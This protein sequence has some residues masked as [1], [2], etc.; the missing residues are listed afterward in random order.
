MT[1]PHAGVTKLLLTDADSW[2]QGVRV[3]CVGIEI[4]V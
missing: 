1:Q 2:F 4:L 3:Q